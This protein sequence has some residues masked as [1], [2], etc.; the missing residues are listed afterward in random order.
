ML[1]V[2]ANKQDQAGALSLSELT[3]KLELNKL[4]EEEGRKWLIQSTCALTGQGIYEGFDW[5]SK[6]INK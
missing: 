3:S 2:F 1:Q 6:V 5:L 4:K